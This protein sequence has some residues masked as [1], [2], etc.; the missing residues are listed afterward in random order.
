MLSV[1]GEKGI[2]LGRTDKHLLVVSEVSSSE[3]K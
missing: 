3:T 1:P 2:C